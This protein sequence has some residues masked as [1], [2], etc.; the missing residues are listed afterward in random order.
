MEHPTTIVV[1]SA[2]LTQELSQHRLP[3][4]YVGVRRV[5]P[6]ATVAAFQS[7][8]AVVDK[9]PV[10]FIQK[11]PE[12]GEERRMSRQEKKAL[13]FKIKQEQQLEK[14]QR[15]REEQQL[16]IEQ[17][18]TQEAANA[19]TAEEK[20]EARSKKRKRDK[21][22]LHIPEFLKGEQYYNLPIHVAALEQELADLTGERNKV[23][24]V[25]VG[26][27]MTRL[28][29]GTPL[30]IV[31]DDELAQSWAVALKH[32]MKPAE[33]VRQAEDLRAMVYD[34]VPSVWSRMRPASIGVSSNSNKSSLRLK[35]GDSYSTMTLH[36]P[37]KADTC[38]AAVVQALHCG[39][40]LHVSCGAKFGGDYLVYD[41]PRDECH[42]FAGLRVLSEDQ[43]IPT[44]YDMTGY[45]RCLHTAAKLALLAMA[46]ERVGQ[47]G[48]P[49]YHVAF[50]ELALIKIGSTR[51]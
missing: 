17:K 44:A 21:I 47:D 50:V 20:E 19:A 7:K 9:S 11:D 43:T 41:A 38:R 32:S 23:P 26:P 8:S 30:K 37:S 15:K 3:P 34:V 48:E 24:P 45:V 2:A 18:Q 46:E 12:T 49:V 35:Q 31:V 6:S 33:I 28:L 51:R 25:A 27:P 10:V 13:K 42:A 29:L 22:L 40:H 5:R 36:A 1:F 16:L 14:K 39:T 4:T